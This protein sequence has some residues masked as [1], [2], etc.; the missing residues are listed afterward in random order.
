MWFSARRGQQ[1]HWELE[2]VG[3]LALLR[4]MKVLLLEYGVFKVHGSRLTKERLWRAGRVG[5]A[6]LSALTGA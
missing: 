2:G 5:N 4:T 1:W 3:N 6:K